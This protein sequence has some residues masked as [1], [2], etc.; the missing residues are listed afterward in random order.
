M[1]ESLEHCSEEVAAQ[2]YAVF[3]RSYKEEAQLIG[4]NE[5]PPLLRTAA[6]IQVATSKFLGLRI[7]SELAAIVEYTNNGAN[8]SID[9]LVVH[10]LFFRRGL[11]SQL[12]QSLLG[13]HAYR[14]ADV[15]TAAANLPA[16]TLYNKFGFFESKRWITDE[17]IEK[18]RL[19]YEDKT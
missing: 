16:I 10:P 8:L 12:L 1:I 19:E 2:I 11:A 14:T 15:E 3:Q 4:V 18:V 13:T 6:N 17:G 9:S 7:G 5:F